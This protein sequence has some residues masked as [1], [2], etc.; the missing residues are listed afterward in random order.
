MVIWLIG[1]SGC[2][3]TTIGT[4]LYRRLKP[5][6]PNLLLLDGDRFREVLGDD[7]GYTYEERARNA[8][9]FSHFCKWLDEQGIHLICC[10]LSNYPEWQRWNRNN[11]GQYFEIFVD[12]DIETL[13]RRDTKR[14]YAEAVAG[15]RASVVGIDIPFTPPPRADLVVENNADLDDVGPIVKRIL[16]A[17]PAFE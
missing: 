1:L 14:I 12:A 13:R 3:K 9:R 6:H 4:E 11:F 17:L 15:T 7:L 16:A 2:G 8:R 5:D 10:V